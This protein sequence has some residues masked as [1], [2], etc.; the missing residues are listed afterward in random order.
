M[1]SRHRPVAGKRNDRERV[2]DC[3]LGRLAG[4]I[5]QRVVHCPRYHP[6]KTISAA[7]DFVL[8]ILAVRGG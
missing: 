5:D 6:L 8:P 3:L 1:N 2:V 7:Q 4:D